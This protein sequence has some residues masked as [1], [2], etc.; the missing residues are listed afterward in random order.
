MAKRRKSSPEDDA[1]SLSLYEQERP[2][3]AAVNDDKEV[4]FKANEINQ[5]ITCP[6]CLAII[7]K[8]MTVMEC[9][10][11]FCE[12]CIEKCL[13]MGRKECPTCRIKCSSR[14]SL[15]ADPNFDA[16][17]HKLYPDL[18]EY[19]SKRERDI[20]NFTDSL[21]LQPL[22]E[23]FSEGLQRQKGKKR[24]RVNSKTNSR[25]FHARSRMDV[26]EPSIPPKVTSKAVSFWLLRHP[27]E[28]TLPNL[29]MPFCSLAG[30]ATVS[31]LLCY[32][33]KKMGFSTPFLIQVAVI[34]ED[35]LHDNTIRRVSN[36]PVHYSQPLSHKLSLQE[37]QRNVPIKPK[38][39]LIIRYALVTC[40][41]YAV[42]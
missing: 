27:N 39:E 38:E 35:Y 42:N 2:V 14:R 13:R 37:I 3:L 40:S 36:N 20:L 33:T 8:T 29:K 12:S 34:A 18:E 16:L 15:R 11:R 10:H 21:D 17:I 28:H 7:H 24:L 25:K 5:F 23:S 1:T 32:L 41:L 22:Q 30:D 4:L 31:V 26:A 19:R 9:L 6:V